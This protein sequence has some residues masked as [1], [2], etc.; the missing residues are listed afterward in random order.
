MLTIK[1]L[2]THYGE[3]AALRGV[4]LTVERGEI[5]TLIGPNGAG[6]TT[7]L[8]TVSN[9]LRPTRG[10]VYYEGMNL[11][12][13]PP[14]RL[15]ALGIAHVPE[16]RRIFKDLTVLENLELGAYHRGPRANLR[17][18]FDRVFD[19][20]PRLYERRR[21]I[22][23]TLSGGEQQMLAIAR[24]LMA[25]PKL[26]MLDEP[27][28]GLAPKVVEQLFETLTTINRQGTT[29]LVVEQNAFAA[30]EV[31]HRGYVLEQGK[32]VLAGSA[33]ELRGTDRVQQL[34]LGGAFA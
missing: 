20:F 21:Q 4:S 30:L 16:G 27:S 22:A 29:I 2:H 8:R 25:E 18:S 13:L 28:M 34:Y 31:A 17:P 9:I 19:L 26:L 10:E 3:I 24:A 1:N 12:R 15:I 6:K 7:L 32:V 5:V 14:Y 23:G 11:L 33:A